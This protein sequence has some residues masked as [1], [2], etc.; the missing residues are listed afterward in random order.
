M[1]DQIDPEENWNIIWKE[2]LE[3][4]DG[5]I[6][7]EQLKLELADYSDMID[8]MTTLTYRLTNG[9]LSYPTYPVETILA[10]HEE[11]LEDTLDYN[12]SFE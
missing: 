10:V 4:P 1:R 6:N 7:K 2:I 8:R 11:V 9:I 5:S 3:N 12:D